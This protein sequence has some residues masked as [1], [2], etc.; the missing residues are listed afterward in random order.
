MKEFDIFRGV[1][2][3]IKLKKRFKEIS[4][5]ATIILIEDKTVRSKD[6]LDKFIL[7]SRWR[8]LYDIRLFNCW[9]STFGIIC[10]I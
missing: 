9:N 4:K 1:K 10:I 8:K 2:F 6:Y 7:K 3:P 5:N